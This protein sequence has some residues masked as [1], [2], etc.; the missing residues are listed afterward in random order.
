MKTKIQALALITV[1]GIALVGCNDNKSTQTT[2]MPQNK[3]GDL[4]VLTSNGMIS[5][6]NR[7]SS[8]KLISNMKVS[9]LQAG[10]ELVGM[11]HRPKD[12]QLYAVGKLGNLYKLNPTTGVATFVVKM[13]ADPADATGNPTPF[14]KITADPDLVT[15]NFNPLADRLRIIG[16]D[17]QNLRVNVDTGLTITDGDINAVANASITS[18]AYTNAF[19]ETGSTKLYSIDAT[20][21]R[22][23]LQNANAG[24]LGVSS[25]LT[26]NIEGGS[27]FD[28]DPINNIGFTT[29]KIANGY[30]LYQLNLANVG[31]TN[32]PVFATTNLPSEYGSTT[33]RGIALNRAEGFKAHGIGLSN[34][35]K[36]ISFE[37]KTPNTVSE[38]TITGI[39]PAEKFLGIDYRLRTTTDNSGKLYGLTDKANLYTIDTDTG[40]A[41][42]ISALKPAAASTFTT[43]QGSNFAVDFNPAADRLR[44]I[45]N[46]GQNLRINVDTG[47]TIADGSI[48]GVAN[49]LISSAAY[50]NSFKSPLTALNPNPIAALATE[51]FDLDL[52]NNILSKQVPPNDGTLVK[53]GDLGITLGTNDGFD[54]AGGDNGLALASVSTN[55]AA[56]VLY[57]IDLNSDTT[58]TTPRARPAILNS[59]TPPAPDLSSSRIGT[60]TTAPLIDLAILLK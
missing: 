54:I 52:T 50:T 25:A 16:G 60:S 17:G 34:D 32:N 23:Y 28:I 6:I 44:V 5:S 51:L 48:N 3:T 14:S 24:T 53:V 33:I 59:A 41:T 37:I 7:D 46:T 36:L 31:T 2:P 58:L 55:N 19:P 21:D 11:D 39:L 45:S 49:A 20:T 29:L 12:N 9:G 13:A 35:N 42:L 18:A 27:G 30:K 47:E 4:L 57:R 8:E 56:S 43:L 40:K 26:G 38:K 10:D 22:I 1:G 15:V